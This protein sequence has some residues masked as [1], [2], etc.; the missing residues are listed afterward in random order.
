MAGSPWLPVGLAVVMIA[1][2]AG[3]AFRLGLGWARRRRLE[4]G[5]DCLHACLGVAMAGMLVPRL[6]L[7]PAAVWATV[8]GGWAIWFGW[9]A[10]T[11]RRAG[12]RTGH[13][14]GDSGTGGPLAHLVECL[15]MSYM[16]LPAAAPSSGLVSTSPAVALLLVLGLA[17][18][19]VWT[20]D[21]LTRARMSAAVSGA[22][23][24]RLAGYGRIAMGLTMGYML[25]QLV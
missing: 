1:I 4:P 8:F 25:I 13:R 10:I 14:A 3:C 23:V 5:S 22:P 18:Y 2:V 12:H 7:L 15:A 9:Q 16:L 19:V 24:P 21:T 17:G 20:T 11:N 6:S